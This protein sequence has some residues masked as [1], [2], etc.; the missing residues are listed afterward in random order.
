MSHPSCLSIIPKFLWKHIIE[1]MSY[2]NIISMTVVDSN[3][4]ILIDKDMGRSNFLEHRTNAIVVVKCDARS[5]DYFWKYAVRNHV[6]CRNV[7]EL[8]YYLEC[9]TE[10]NITMIYYKVFIKAGEY[11]L[12]DSHYNLYRYNKQQCSIEINGSKS[13]TTTFYFVIPRSTLDIVISSFFSMK[14]I[15]FNDLFL[16]LQKH[17]MTYRLDDNDF[18]KILTYRELYISN[19]A[20]GN[21]KS[22]LNIESIDKSTII[23]C[24]FNH[25]QLWITGCWR[26]TELIIRLGLSEIT[27]CNILSSTFF[28]ESDFCGCI[29]IRGGLLQVINFTDNVVLKA[30]ILF[31]NGLNNKTLIEAKSNRIYN[32]DLCVRRCRDT[33]FTNNQFDNVISLH[34]EACNNIVIDNTNTFINCGEQ[35]MNQ[36]KN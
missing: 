31:S 25:T 1:Y 13:E 15:R 10:K 14:Y 6:S 26:V 22:G 28:D 7:N 29:D 33:T 12:D 19:C 5:M 23:N 27:V 24:Q 16:N 30:K 3:F 2:E 36:I 21:G 35:L 9:D 32:T 18:I 34:D 4:F 20:F 8:F 17:G 11:I